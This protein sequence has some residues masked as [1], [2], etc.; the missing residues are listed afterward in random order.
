MP[1]G[2]PEPGNVNAMREAIAAHCGAP[3]TSVR[4]VRSVCEIGSQTD[5]P[6]MFGSGP[7][8]IQ[9]KTYVADGT[10]RLRSARADGTTLTDDVLLPGHPV[11]IRP[12]DGDPSTVVI[13]NVVEAA[14]G[15]EDAQAITSRGLQFI[16]SAQAMIAGGSGEAAA[17]RRGDF[18]WGALKLIYR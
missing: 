10:L 18:S 16:R 9:L 13:A 6:M 12:L 14:R 7:A 4:L 15:G 1:L 17:R 8:A 5:D 11:A 3:S 2:G